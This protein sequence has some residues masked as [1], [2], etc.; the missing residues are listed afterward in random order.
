M[1][2]TSDLNNFTV[3]EL[4]LALSNLIYDLSALEL[5]AV[6]EVEYYNMTLNKAFETLQTDNNSK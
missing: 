2:K 1:Y 5:S 4:Q 3:L 6:Q